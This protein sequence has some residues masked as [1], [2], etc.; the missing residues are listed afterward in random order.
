MG[1]SRKLS[2]QRFRQ[3]GGV[4]CLLILSATTATRG[5]AALSGTTER[6]RRLIGERHFPASEPAMD[7]RQQFIVFSPDTR[8]SR[9]LLGEV[10]RLRQRIYRFFG[11]SKIWDQPAFVLIFPSKERYGL[12]GTGGAAIHFRYQGE[13]VRIIGSYLQEGLKDKILP[14]EMVHFLIKDLSAVGAVAAG[15]PPQLPVFIEEG[16]AEY[17]TAP[18]ARR[19]LYEKSAW[20]ALEAGNL[21][22]LKKIVTDTGSWVDALIPDSSSWPQRS[23]SYSVISFLASLPRGNVKLKNYIMSYGTLANRVPAESASLR[24]FEMA[25]R[26][27]YSSLEGFQQRWVQYIREREFVVLEAEAASVADSSGEAC[28]VKSSP[29]RKLPLSGGKELQFHADGARSSLTLR[30]NLPRPGA[31][32]LYAIYAQRPEGGRFQVTVN[33]KTFPKTFDS[34]A[35][36]EALCEPVYYGKSLIGGDGAMIGFSVVGKQ[37]IS[38]G[39]AIG[40]DCLLFRRD[41]LLERKNAASAQRQVQSGTAYYQRKQF[42]E[43]EAKFTAAIHLAPWDASGLEWRAYSRMALGRL[44]EAQQDVEA[45]LKLKPDNSRLTELGKRINEVREKTSPSPSNEAPP[46]QE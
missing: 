30:T 15:E 20:D 45:A 41:A 31:Y 29:K 37:V 35:R 7:T 17:F 18:Q 2:F 24:A 22:P 14:H 13:N 4:L 40:I 39:Y 21:E 46:P 16:I 8:L 32:D 28:E 12:L 33:G 10:F 36:T 9:E 34:Y 25:F 43:A 6:I 42:R 44:G 19:I 27:D 3:F 26:Q 38:S 23:Q 1:R 11:V 5:W